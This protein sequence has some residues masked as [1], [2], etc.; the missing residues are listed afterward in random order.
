[1]TLMENACDIC[2]DPTDGYVCRKEAESTDRSLHVIIDLAPE[3]ETTVSRQS[4]YATRGGRRARTVPDEPEERGVNRRMPV[5]AFAW[6]AS[7]DRPKRG[8]LRSTPMP[9]DLGASERSAAAFNAITTCAR[10]ISED[11]GVPLDSTAGPL[12]GAEC[13]H[14]SC[15]LIR[16]EE[17]ANH[18]AVAAAWFLIEQLAWLRHQPAGAEAMRELQDAA[19][20]I[21]RIVDAPPELVIVGVCDCDAHLYAKLDAA[22]VTCEECKARWDVEASR[23]LLREAL[24]DRL[25]TAAEGATLA[26]MLHP[27]EQ[28]DKVR[29]MIQGWARPDR[30]HLTEHP[31]PK[32]PRYPFGEIIDRVTRHVVAKQQGR[33]ATVTAN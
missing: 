18:P 2:G 22:T 27:T 19:S 21:R 33:G 15:R 4:R 13:A 16:A 17:A 6:N 26:V 31:G 3:V 1:M 12:C 24:R 14:S 11:R 23:D 32:G 5:P 29:N 8:A 20:D 7:K 9:V 25:V 10:H 30:A 28:R